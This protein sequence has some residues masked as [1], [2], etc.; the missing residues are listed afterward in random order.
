MLLARYDLSAFSKAERVMI[1]RLVLISMLLG[2]MTP[3]I[4]S[5]GCAHTDE[6]GI[7]HPARP[8]CH[9]HE[10]LN[11]D[12]PSDHDVDAIYFSEDDATPP[13]ANAKVIA[14][15]TVV[16]AVFAHVPALATSGE[17]EYRH[18]AWSHPPPGMTI[19][20]TPLYLQLLAIL[21]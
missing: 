6:R 2:V 13:N 12:E 17:I 16:C 7:L 5:A 8:H 14:D 9:L 10:H 3:R 19:P 18:H 15:H 21:L 11:G 1:G 4:F 20:A